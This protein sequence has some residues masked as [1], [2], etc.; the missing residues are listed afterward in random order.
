MSEAR[1][2]RAMWHRVNEYSSIVIA[3]LVML[4]M[5]AL[6]K[7]GVLPVGAEAMW[8]QLRLPLW[9]MTV[10]AV[11]ELLA[12]LLLIYH[13][14]RLLGGLLT[15]CVML[16][17]AVANLRAG[18]PLQNLLVN[19]IVFVA[20]LNVMRFGKDDFMAMLGR[21]RTAPVSGE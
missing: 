15:A 8:M 7:L 2:P 16:G 20:A 19:L 14:T 3:F 4:L 5:G 10:T 21:G 18:L 12:A 11:I 1:N 13:R 17:A 9:F 6:P